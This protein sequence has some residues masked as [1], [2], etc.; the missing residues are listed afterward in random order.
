MVVGGDVTDYV[1]SCPIPMLEVV[2]KLGE[3]G[4]DLTWKLHCQLKR[5]DKWLKLHRQ[6]NGNDERLK[7]LVGMK[8]FMVGS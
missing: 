8:L 5:Y 3:K 1:M 7:W 6:S 4:D 2:V